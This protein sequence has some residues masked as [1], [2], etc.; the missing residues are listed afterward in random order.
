[1]L[2][3]LE[4]LGFIRKKTGSLSWARIEDVAQHFEI[5]EINARGHVERLLRNGHIRPVER[6]DIYGR[7]LGLSELEF[8]ITRQGIRRLAYMRGRR[9]PGGLF[10]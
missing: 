10:D 7:K 8:R 1:M 4:V 2:S 5:P 9:P 6:E 3:N